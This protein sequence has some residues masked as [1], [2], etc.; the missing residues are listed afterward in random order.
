[1][2][3]FHVAFLRG[4]SKSSFSVNS[5]FSR[6]QR[7]RVKSKMFRCL[8]TRNNTRNN[9]ACLFTHRCYTLCSCTAFS[10]TLCVWSNIRNSGNESPTRFL[11][12]WIKPREL[13]SLSATQERILMKFE[14]KTEKPSLLESP[15]SFSLWF[16]PTYCLVNIFYALELQA[17]LIPGCLFYFCKILTS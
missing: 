12:K 15:A 11:R 13:W 2:L 14:S 3:I 1:M 6:K 16:Q 8:D 7:I 10:V 9:A 17:I 5:F 4:L